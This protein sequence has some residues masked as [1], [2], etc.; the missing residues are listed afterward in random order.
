[1][2]IHGTVVR[3]LLEN[4]PSRAGVADVKAGLGMQSQASAA[5]LRPAT[6][7]HFLFDQLSWDL[8]EDAAQLS[9]PDPYLGPAK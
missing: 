5:N 6:A 8:G 2:K 4:L 9:L 3:E 7:D 1:M